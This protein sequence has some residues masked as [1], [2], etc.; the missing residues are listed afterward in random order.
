MPILLLGFLADIVTWKFEDSKIGA[1]TLK[2]Y[3]V[4]SWRTNLGFFGWRM[5]H[6]MKK[7]RRTMAQKIPNPIRIF[8]ISLD[9][10]LW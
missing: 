1:D 8:L 9:L 3:I 4:A 7:T 6:V 2:P 5:A 10:L